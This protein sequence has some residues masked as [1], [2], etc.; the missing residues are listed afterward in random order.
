[1]A[2]NRVAYPYVRD[3]R[4]V[5][6][7]PWRI[8]AREW[9]S[10]TTTRSFETGT[11]DDG[12]SGACLLVSRPSDESEPVPPQATRRRT[13]VRTGAVDRRSDMTIIGR[14]RSRAVRSG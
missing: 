12:V 2:W 7:M 8:S 13:A 11:T 4:S 6:G 14:P 3:T 5:Y 10:T 9:F 1:M